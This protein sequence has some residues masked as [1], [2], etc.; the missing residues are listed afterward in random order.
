MSNEFYQNIPWLILSLKP[1]GCGAC[2]FINFNSC[3]C[4]RIFLCLFEELLS[5]KMFYPDCMF[6]MSIKKILVFARLFHSTIVLSKS[7]LLKST[8]LTNILFTATLI[9]S[10]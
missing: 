8:S 5:D 4:Q 7:S 2:F 9:L 6:K 10:R 1:S 3:S